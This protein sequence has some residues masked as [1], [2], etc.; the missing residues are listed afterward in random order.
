MATKVED[1][2]NIEISI[3]QTEIFNLPLTQIA[4]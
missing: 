1:Q 3:S 4:L 2:W